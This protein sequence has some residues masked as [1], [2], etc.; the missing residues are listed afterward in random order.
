ML[1]SK[2]SV[3]MYLSPVSGKSVTIFLSLFS[4]C[5]ARS[6]AAYNAA[7]EDIP[8]TIPSVLAIILPVESASSSL[9]DIT[10]SYIFVFKT[11][12]IKTAPIP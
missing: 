2:S 4:I 3:D 10:S 6:V 8:T 11:L 5:L 1:Y 9:T 7:P 12:G